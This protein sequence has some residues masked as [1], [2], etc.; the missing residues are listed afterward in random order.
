MSTLSKGLLKLRRWRGKKRAAAFFAQEIEELFA[1]QTTRNR[2]IWRRLDPAYGQA[3]SPLYPR[4]NRIVAK[5]RRVRPRTVIKQCSQFLRPTHVKESFVT[6]NGSI[7]S[8][9][10][11]AR[12][13]FTSG[14]DGK[15]YSTSTSVRVRLRGHPN[16]PSMSIRISREETLWRQYQYSERIDAYVHLEDWDSDLHEYHD[17]DDDIDDDYSSDADDDDDDS[18]E[19]AFSYGTDVLRTPTGQAGFAF[20]GQNKPDPKKL[21]L[22]VELEVEVP[23]HVSLSDAY[24]NTMGV[25][26]KFA[27][28]K[29]DGSLNRGFEIV[30]VPM[31]LDFHR[32]VWDDFFVSK[33]ITELHSQHT[34]GMHVHVSRD[35]VGELAVAKLVWFICG[36]ERNH[37]HHK[38]LNDIAGRAPNSYC[39]R[40]GAGF[41]KPRHT[42]GRLYYRK[43]EKK[44]LFDLRGAINTETNKPTIEFRLFNSTLKRAEF[45]AR[46]EFAAAAVAF[47]NVTSIAHMNHRN[48]LAWFRLSGNTKIY[49]NL[50]AELRRLQYLESRPPKP[51]QILDLVA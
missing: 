19:H 3:R 1:V 18:P 22:G 48:F 50:A 28:G 23:G 40:Q 41:Y 33:A 24:Q 2:D 14:G 6:A 15:I 37:D 46:I 45:L 30:S 35:A 51:V 47:A 36:N 10:A 7:I 5:L 31:T 42:S 20:D 39:S 11:Y 29:E 43:A 49:P 17:Y 4:L 38:F 26:G 44:V 25:V 34:T 27:I 32:K 13:Y 8:R 21:Y 9:E 12:Y 16:N